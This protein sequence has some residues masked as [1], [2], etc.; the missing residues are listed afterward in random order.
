MT[1]DGIRSLFLMQ[2][3]ICA[4]RVDRACAFEAVECT[5]AHNKEVIVT[6]GGGSVVVDL[7]QFEGNETALKLDDTVS[8]RW[9]LMTSDDL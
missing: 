3:S 5:F 2:H 1:L 4:V 9:P 6:R 8:G 7:C